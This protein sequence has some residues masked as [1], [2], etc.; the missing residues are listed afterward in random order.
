M[1][2]VDIL[3]FGGQSNMQGQSDCLSEAEEVVGAFEYRFTSDALVPLKNPVGEDITYDGHR[4]GYAYRN[5]LNASEWRAK[6]VLGS[7]CYG[8]TNLVPAFCRAYIAQ[9]K[10]EVIAVH[11][12]KGS[13]RVC[14]WLPGTPGFDALV[15][16]ASA[17]R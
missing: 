11:V 1:K 15:K 7:A 5:G 6:H 2:T 14:D 4:L 13:T 8:Y 12:A 17:A 16:K 10:H 9:T 3:I